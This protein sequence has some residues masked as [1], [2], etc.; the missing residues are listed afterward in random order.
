MNYKTLLKLDY[1][2]T[3]DM[4]I[5]LIYNSA[6]YADVFSLNEIFEF[7]YKMLKAEDEEN[8]I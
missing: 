1:S 4:L 6:K 8:G 7:E 3:E 5:R 2:Y